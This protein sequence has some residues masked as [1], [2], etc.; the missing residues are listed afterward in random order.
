[1]GSGDQCLQAL[2]HV[3][4]KAGC[5]AQEAQ[6]MK[7]IDKL[8][9]YFENPSDTTIFIIAYKGKTYDKRTKLY[10][11]ISKQADVFIR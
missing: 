2:P 3:C 11:L 8:E 7:D 9:P 10:K 5:L 4:R 6:Q 1:M